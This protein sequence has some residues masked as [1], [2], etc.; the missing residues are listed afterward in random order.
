MWV[1]VA[2]NDESRDFK[3]GILT[4]ESSELIGLFFS[5]GDEG[6]FNDR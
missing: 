3:T 4:C 6:P 1:R 5:L 2:V